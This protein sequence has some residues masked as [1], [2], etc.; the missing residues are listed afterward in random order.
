[1]KT[2]LL[3][4]LLSIPPILAGS[5]RRVRRV[6]LVET[7]PGN[8]SFSPVHKEVICYNASCCK[9][10]CCPWYVDL[11]F[12]FF[13]VLLFLLSLKI[14]EKCWHKYCRVMSE[15]SVTNESQE[16][17]LM[18]SA[19]QSICASRDALPNYGSNSSEVPALPAYTDDGL[20]TYEEAVSA[21]R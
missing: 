8:S 11:F 7:Q 5:H 13:I 3:F 19:N 10:G 12:A 14:I 17:I 20:P 6:C 2:I 15:R 9:K 18:T 1:M 21:K 4:S 16:N